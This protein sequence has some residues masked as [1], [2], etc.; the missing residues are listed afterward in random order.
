MP[1]NVDREFIKHFNVIKQLS[2]TP[3]YGIPA[4]KYKKT[5]ML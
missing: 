1:L 4:H 2:L 3:K 5:G